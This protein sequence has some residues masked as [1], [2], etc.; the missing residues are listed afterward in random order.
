MGKLVVTLVIVLFFGCSPDYSQQQ[1]EESN[2]TTQNESLDEEID[3]IEKNR[4]K[5]K[6]KD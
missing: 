4:K 1:L 2:E 5:H 6:P 3:D